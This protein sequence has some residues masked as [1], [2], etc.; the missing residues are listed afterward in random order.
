MG[1]AIQ[2]RKKKCSVL[3]IFLSLSVRVGPLFAA[4]YGIKQEYETAGISELRRGYT[5][6]KH[7]SFSLYYADNSKQPSPKRPSATA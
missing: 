7:I 6:R 1:C 2:K 5:V 3:F 4:V